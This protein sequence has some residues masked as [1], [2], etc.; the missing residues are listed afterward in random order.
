MPAYPTDLT[1]P[2]SRPLHRACPLTRP[3]FSPLQT[4]TSV[5]Y[6]TTPPRCRAEDPITAS[7]RDGCDASFE[8]THTRLVISQRKRQCKT[9]TYARAGVRLWFVH[10]ACCAGVVLGFAV[11]PRAAGGI[12]QEVEGGTGSSTW[13]F[14]VTKRRVWFLCA[15]TSRLKCVAK[16]LL[17][18]KQTLRHGKRFPT[19]VYT[20]LLQECEDG[21]GT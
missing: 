20:V 16:A 5:N 14:N 12:P 11:R 2:A 17:R 3:A 7:E 9:V 21:C 15:S 18:E 10:G 6:P 8:H 4:T 1:H 19:T 13:G